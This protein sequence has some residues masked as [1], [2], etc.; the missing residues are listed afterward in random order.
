MK[1][2]LTAVMI[3]LLFGITMFVLSFNTYSGILTN[4]NV[5]VGSEVQEFRNSLNPAFSEINGTTDKLTEKSGWEKVGSKLE[6]TLEYMAIG[7]SAMDV[8][9]SMPAQLE[10]LLI[11]VKGNVTWVDE[12]LYAV[13]TTAVFILIFAMIVKSKKTTSD[14]T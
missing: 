7:W 10:T 14:I 13:F 9:F 1:S 4:N 6:S 8:F 12:S 2:S 5:T 3:G 11:S